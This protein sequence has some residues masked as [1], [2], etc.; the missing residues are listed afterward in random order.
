[1][2]QAANR[3][4]NQ[5]AIFPGVSRQPVSSPWSRLGT[6]APGLAETG[7]G[8]GDN[9]PTALGQRPGCQQRA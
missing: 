1:L 4:E 6:G 9:T 7:G 8:G 5:T 3:F 2:V